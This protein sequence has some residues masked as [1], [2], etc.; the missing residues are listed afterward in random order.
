MKFPLLV[1]VTVIYERVVYIC[2]TVGRRIRQVV[3]IPA[4]VFLKCLLQLKGP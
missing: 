2:R 3:F 4:Q 1:G